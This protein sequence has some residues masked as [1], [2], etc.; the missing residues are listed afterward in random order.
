MQTRPETRPET[1]LDTLFADYADSH[2]TRGNRICHSIGIPLIV[3]AVLGLPPLPVALAIFALTGFW[4]IY[5][6]PRLGLAFLFVSA[7][8]L[9]L[10]QRIPFWPLFIAF[11]LGWIFQ[12]VGHARF[13]KKSPSFSSNAR[14]ILVGPIW[15][16]AKAVGAGRG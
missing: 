7:G 8:A 2:R 9:V 4:Y 13:E 6:D 5:Q 11:G 14:H 16:F 3:V 12:L 15:I 10:G 1:R